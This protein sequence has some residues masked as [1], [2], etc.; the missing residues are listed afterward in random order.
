MGKAADLTGQRFGKWTVLERVENDKYGS[1]MWLCRC[2]CGAELIISGSDLSLNRSTKCKS[3]S[4]Y[5]LRHYEI[6][7]VSVTL[8]DIAKYAGIT[9]QTVRRRIKAGWTPEEII[10]G[11]RDGA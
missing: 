3:C 4:G 10:R 1:A 5:A 2:D 9:V 11:R 8:S 6:N 7:G